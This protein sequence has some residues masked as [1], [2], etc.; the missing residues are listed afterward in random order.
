MFEVADD[1]NIQSKMS[2]AMEKPEIYKSIRL[3]GVDIKRQFSVGGWWKDRSITKLD[4]QELP[5]QR[6]EN[7]IE[8]EVDYQYHPDEYNLFYGEDIYETAWNKLKLQ[9]EIDSIYLVGDF[10][11][12]SRADFSDGDRGALFTQGPFY[13]GN[14]PRK[15]SGG[16][17]TAQGFCFYA[18]AMTLS[19][20]AQIHKKAGERVIFRMNRPNATLLVLKINDKFEKIIPWAPY[21]VDVTDYVDDGLNKLEIK[22]YSSNR[23]LFGPFH[24]K[25]GQLNWT[26]WKRF[27][28]P[29]NWLDCK[30]ED[31][32][33]TDR[34]CF[35]RFGLN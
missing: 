28:D 33:W 27:I 18:G 25:L 9:T 16:N 6:G 20:T 23:N 8:M 5:L 2:V 4:L 21:E 1:F 3:N 14:A 26:P 11:V 31:S 15:I 12:F 10:G 17:I 30:P 22:L 19:Q 24:H 29:A 13:L 32:Y 35:Y 7:D 34:Y